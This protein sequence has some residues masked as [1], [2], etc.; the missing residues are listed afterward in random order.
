MV[1]WMSGCSIGSGM[2]SAV[3]DCYGYVC[4]VIWVSIVMRAWTSG[5]H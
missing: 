2:Q 1:G 5:E 3:W 4:N